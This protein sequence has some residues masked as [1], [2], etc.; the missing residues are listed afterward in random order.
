MNCDI[1]GKP[2]YLCVC[3]GKPTE[4]ILTNDP[5]GYPVDMNALDQPRY[6]EEQLKLRDIFACACMQGMMSIENLYKELEY[7]EIAEVAYRQ[8]DAMLIER[9]NERVD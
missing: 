2:T 6:T 4:P 8:A 5:S 9:D 3:T 1:C 7:D